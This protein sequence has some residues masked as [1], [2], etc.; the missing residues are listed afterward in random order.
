MVRLPKARLLRLPVESDL[1]SSSGWCRLSKYPISPCVCVWGVFVCVCV[2]V[3]V[4]GCGC[5]GATQFCR[6]SVDALSIS[7]CCILKLQGF[8][9]GFGSAKV[10][11]QS[12]SRRRSFRHEGVLISTCPSQYTSIKNDGGRR[13]G[14]SR[15]VPC[16][17]R[18]DC[19]LLAHLVMPRERS[20]PVSPRPS[21]TS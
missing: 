21:S 7:T 18:S 12:M 10:S 13:C 4:C 20:C 6:C 15:P 16:R 1:V 17:T 11:H 5:G 14:G 19:V 8:H 9:F 2:C 3:C